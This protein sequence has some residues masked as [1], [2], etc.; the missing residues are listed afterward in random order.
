MGGQGGSG[1]GGGKIMAWWANGGWAQGRDA[2]RGEEGG[3]HILQP[4]TCFE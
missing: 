3:R 2:L 1:G 4:A